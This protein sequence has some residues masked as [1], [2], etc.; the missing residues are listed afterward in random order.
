MTREEATIEA[1]SI[2]SLAYHSIGDATHAADGFCCK[3][4]WGEGNQESSYR[5]EGRIFEYVR[6]AVMEKLKRDGH[7]IDSGFDPKTGIEKGT[8]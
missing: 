5:N 4:P 3:C 1:C 6:R 8:K 2:F 7:E